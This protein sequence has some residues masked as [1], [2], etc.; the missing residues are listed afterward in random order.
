[1]GS[2]RK[3]ARESRPSNVVP[4][5]ACSDSPPVLIDLP[6]PINAPLLIIQDFFVIGDPA[7][8]SPYGK[9]YGEHIDWNSDS[10]HDD[11]AIKSTLDTASF[12]GNKDRSMPF[13]PA[14]CD[15]QK[16]ILLIQGDK[17]LIAFLL[18]YLGS[19]S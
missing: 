17:Q 16:R 9:H 6:R 18:D 3:T 12:P 5:S 2:P 10:P 13:P 15:I 1:M 19:W 11:A 7:R 8:H 14:V 4:R